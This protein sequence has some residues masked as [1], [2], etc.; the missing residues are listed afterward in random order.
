MTTTTMNE[1]SMATRPLH[2]SVPSH[3]ATEMQVLSAVI[4]RSKFQ[5]RSQPFLRRMREVLRLGSRVGHI[6]ANEDTEAVV[7]D[8]KRKVEII[9]RVCHPK[10][11]GKWADE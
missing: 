5:H 11:M 6:L 3:L 8:M 4:E 7:V 10:S 9:V 2:S 1:L